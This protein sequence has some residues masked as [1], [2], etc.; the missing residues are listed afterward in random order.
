MAR[1]IVMPPFDSEFFAGRDRLELA[2]D[3]LFALVSALDGEAPG[4]AAIAQPRAT[5]A[6]DGVVT[7]DWATPLSPASE[8]V[9]LP[10]VGG[11]WA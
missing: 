5:F 4:F 8:V 3:S 6:V 10:R 1:V 11:G 9:L 7:P 2:A